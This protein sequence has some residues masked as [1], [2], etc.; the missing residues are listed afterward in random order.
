[1]SAPKK[2]I[3]DPIN[4]VSEMIEGLLLQF[5]NKLQKLQNHNVLLSSSITHDKVSVYHSK[6]VGRF[7]WSND[8][9]KAIIDAVSSHDIPGARAAL[10]EDI[11]RSYDELINSFSDEIK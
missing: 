11:T 6:W 1:M 9:H 4:A 3:N 5:P 7:K 2:F 8:N 10:T